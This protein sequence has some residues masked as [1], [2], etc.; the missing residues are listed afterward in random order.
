MICPYDTRITGPD[1]RLRPRTDPALAHGPA[2]SR[3]RITRTRQLASWSLAAAAGT[4]DGAAPSSQ[5]ELRGLPR[6]VASRAAAHG[7]AGDQAGL[8][9]Q[10]AARS[11]PT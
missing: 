5:R 9:V 11:A 6:F 4:A 3:T 1:S 7:L 8:L 2:P 10:A